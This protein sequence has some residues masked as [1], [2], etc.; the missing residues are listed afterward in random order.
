MK[1]HTILRTAL[2]SVLLSM[3]AVGTTLAQS[4]NPASAKFEQS[5][6][7]SFPMHHAQA[8]E[9]AQLCVQKATHAELKDICQQMMTMQS[10]EKQTMEDWLN[11]WYGGKG[12][13]SASEE[14]KMKAQHEAM[15]AKLKA[16]QGPAFDHAFIMSMDQHHQM[17]IASTGSCIAHAGHAELKE[18]CTKMKNEQQDDTSKMNK[19]MKQWM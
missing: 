14:A 1:I 15:M 11:S 5:F 8:I 7:E 2:C 17:G 18:L 19:L 10:Q 4:N 9:M 3:G 12:M 13:A 6:L 16:A